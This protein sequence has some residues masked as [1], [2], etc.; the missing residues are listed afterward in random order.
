MGVGE[1]RQKSPDR[2]QTS[3]VIN[4]DE[5]IK[6]KK[7]KKKRKNNPPGRKKSAH[8]ETKKNY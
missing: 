2:N 8:R 4:Y 5:T 7:K 6:K 3:T 1:K